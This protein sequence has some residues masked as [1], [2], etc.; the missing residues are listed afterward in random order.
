MPMFADVQDI[1]KDLEELYTEMGASALYYISTK[2]NNIDNI[3][4]YALGEISGEPVKVLGKV[5]Q[6]N[7]EAEKVSEVGKQKNLI[8]Y[9]VTILK[10]SLEE[11]GIL[12]INLE[13]KIK[14]NNIILKIQSIKPSIVLGD[15]FVQ[16]VLEC[17]GDPSK[18]AE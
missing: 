18:N 6:E 8:K 17:L 9:T 14:Y 2:H 11:Q 10:S 7:P 4:N 13:D 12:E 1:S 3:Y 5:D 15:Y 16:Y